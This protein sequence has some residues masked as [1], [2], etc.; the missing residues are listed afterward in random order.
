MR[1]ILDF[2]DAEDRDRG[3]A[4]GDRGRNRFHLLQE[5]FRGM[6]QRMI[7]RQ[8]LRRQKLRRQKLRRQNSRQN[9]N[10][11]AAPKKGLL[12]KEEYSENRGNVHL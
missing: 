12:L 6:Y 2:P 8:K 5:L 4:S 1:C 7:R 3:L 11:C 10:S 9:K